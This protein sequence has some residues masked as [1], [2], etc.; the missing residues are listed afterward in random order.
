MKSKILV[1]GSSL[2]DRGG[3]V[4]VIKNIK[5][6]II[7]E[8]Y[9]LDIVETYITGSIFMRIQ[10]FLKGLFQY[11]NKILNEKPDLIHIHMSYKGS[12][13]RKSIF[14]LIGK[15]FKIPVIIHIH[16]STFKQ[17]YY[18]LNS[19][20]KSYCD[21]ILGKADSLIVLSEEWKTFFSKIVSPEKIVIIYNGILSSKPE[22]NYNHKQTPTF[23][24][25]GRL[26]ERKG[27][28]DLLKA[29]NNLSKKNINSKFWFAGDGEI[30]KTEK[31]IEEYGIGN[32][33]KIIG[34]TSGKK[35]IELL[36]EADVLVLPSYNEGLPMAILE[37]M[38]YGLAIISSPVGGIPEVIVD[39]Q[40]GFLVQP[41]DITAL[42]N[43][44]TT[45]I[46]DS[47]LRIRMGENNQQKVKTEF[48][49]NVILKELS[50]VYERLINKKK[51]S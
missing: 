49:L 50:R 43:A 14:L 38:D 22:I 23:L 13:Y 5:N 20:Q 35:K 28:Y 12:F 25:L 4:T 30:K 39:Y 17:F 27:T 3:I 44:L 18:G 34:W 42:E 33:T 21:F 45:L 41:G 32:I 9:D 16:G 15:S 51:V 48:E 36:K 8:Q 2:K 19:M 31:I 47:K 29:I 46:E 24:F 7:N 37:A 10:I 11:L 1:V 6:S 40:N 26:G